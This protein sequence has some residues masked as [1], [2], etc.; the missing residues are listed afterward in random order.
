LTGHMKLRVG[1]LWGSGSNRP[2]EGRSLVRGRGGVLTW[3]GHSVEDGGGVG[4]LRSEVDDE[5]E[6]MSGE[7]EAGVMRG[8]CLC[9]GIRYEISGALVG[10]LNCHCSMC[11][12]ATGAAFRTRAS[13]RA[14]DFRFV[15]GEQLL[16][17]YGSSPG[18]VRTFCSVCG[19]TLITIFPD[20]PEVLGLALGTL[21]DDPK[22]Q[23]GLHVFVGSKAPWCCISDE[24]PRYETVPDADELARLGLGGSGRTRSTGSD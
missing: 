12:K 18:N 5:G 7:A 16:A 10:T 3:G 17:R 6:G 20:E 19:S 24:L 23:A 13:V 8:S 9:G 22:V 14:G 2:G 11:R 1:G 21:D 15:V 4:A